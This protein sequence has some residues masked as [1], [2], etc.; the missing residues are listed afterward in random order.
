M[1]RICL[2]YFSIDMF[3]Q[4][5]YVKLKPLFDLLRIKKKENE[6]KGRKENEEKKKEK[7]K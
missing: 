6:R 3:V 1:R 4:Y 2:M 5:L 7:R